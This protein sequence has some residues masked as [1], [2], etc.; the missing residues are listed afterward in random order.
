MKLEG[1]FQ[2]PHEIQ[3]VLPLVLYF[4]CSPKASNN[5]ADMRKFLNAL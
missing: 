5:P 2:A 4:F 3:H 1:P